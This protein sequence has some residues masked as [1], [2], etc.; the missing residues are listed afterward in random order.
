MAA[1]LVDD[2]FRR[3]F[4]NEKFLISIKFSLKFVPKCPIDNIPAL[5]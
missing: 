4:V 2:I 3:I 5:V 1:I